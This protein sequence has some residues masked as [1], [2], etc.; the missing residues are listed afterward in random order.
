MTLLSFVVKRELTLAFMQTFCPQC[1]LNSGQQT[2]IQSSSV[3]PISFQV[4]PSAPD[5]CFGLASMVFAGT[6]L[7][8]LAFGY[9]VDRYGRRPGAFLESM[10]IVQVD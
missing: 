2:T 4:S 5:L 8:Q 3:S 10:T 7:G 9:L 1:I 6:V